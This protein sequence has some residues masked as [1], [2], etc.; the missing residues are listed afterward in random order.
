MRV[1][2]CHRT[3]HASQDPC[4]PLPSH[5]SSPRVVPRASAVPLLPG[6]QSRPRPAPRSPEHP[7][8]GLSPGDAQPPAPSSHGRGR[9]Q[10]GHVCLKPRAGPCFLHPPPPPG[11][12][13]GG[14]L[15]HCSRQGGRAGREASDPEAGSP[16]P[17]PR[18]GAAIPCGA[19]SGPQVSG[20]A[21]ASSI[22]RGVRGRGE[23]ASGLPSV[24]TA[25]GRAPSASKDPGAR[26]P[27]PYTEAATGQGLHSVP[28]G[29]GRAFCSESEH[30][31]ARPREPWQHGRPGVTV[32]TG[33]AVALSPRGEKA[34]ER[35]ER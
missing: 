34:T 25:R 12:R 14:G 35:K 8:P 2:R 31:E 27:S 33:R 29:C 11:A 19:R 26:D 10:G 9:G 17:A 16:P 20:D 23:G 28:C 15:G 4:R 13:L 7:G 32:G 24:R 22:P 5:Q 18:P 6:G 21:P 3:V 1:T 30:G